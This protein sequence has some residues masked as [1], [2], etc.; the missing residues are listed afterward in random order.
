MTGNG[1]RGYLVNGVENKVYVMYLRDGSIEF[2]YK[3]GGLP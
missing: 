2:I 1:T 3:V